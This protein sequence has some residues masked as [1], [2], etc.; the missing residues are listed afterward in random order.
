MGFGILSY[1]HELFWIM[2][3]HNSDLDFWRFYTRKLRNFFLNYSHLHVF[4]SERFEDA[5]LHVL[6]WHFC[7]RFHMHIICNLSELRR[8]ELFFFLPLNPVSATNMFEIWHWVIQS[9]INSHIYTDI[10]L[11]CP[12]CRV[13]DCGNDICIGVLHTL[14]ILG[15]VCVHVTFFNFTPSL[16]KLYSI[17]TQPPHSENKRK[18]SSWTWS[19]TYKVKYV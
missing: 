13:A 5:H 6:V 17:Q 4:T 1:I 14:W 12:L 8:P 3:Y 7:S 9:K 18:K 16:W 11:Q 2:H 19:L 10:V 15:L